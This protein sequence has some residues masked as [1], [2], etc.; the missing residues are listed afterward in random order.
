MIFTETREGRRFVGEVPPGLALVEALRSL[1]DNYRITSGW[2]DGTGYVRDAY[3][4]PM[5]ADGTMGEPACLAGMAM[6]AS[7]RAVVSERAGARDL[8]VRAHLTT[9]DG[10]VR[11][12]VLDEATSGSVELV[13]QTFDD[14]TLR[15]YED[16]ETGLARWMDVAVNVISADPSGVRSGRVAMEAMPSRLLEEHEMPQLKVGDALEH[17]RLG[18]CLIT[19][20]TDSDRVNIEMHTGKVAQLHLGLLTLAPAASRDGRTVYEVQVRRRST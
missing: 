17:P 8:I 19:Q 13:A 20:V 18:F 5:R 14:I 12:G 3:L 2:F 11:A 16:P 6:I 10:V 15:R 9:A 7:L 4:R 1:A